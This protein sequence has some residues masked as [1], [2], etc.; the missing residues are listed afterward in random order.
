MTVFV[1]SNKKLYQIYLIGFR[2]KFVLRRDID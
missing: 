2:E 1:N